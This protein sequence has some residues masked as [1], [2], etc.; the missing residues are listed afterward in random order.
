MYGRIPV[1]AWSI[2]ERKR[3][4]IP[5]LCTYLL[6]DTGYITRRKPADIRTLREIIKNLL[7]TFAEAC[8]RHRWK[9]PCGNLRSRLGCDTSRSFFLLAFVKVEIKHQLTGIFR[10]MSN[11][12]GMFEF[13]LGI[14]QGIYA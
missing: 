1:I 14:L 5:A 3:S 10:V 8:K 11:G 7:T 13:T 4:L 12:S 6:D 9:R 2:L